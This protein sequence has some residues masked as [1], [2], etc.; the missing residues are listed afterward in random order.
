M[1]SSCF[2]AEDPIRVD[3]S[4][5]MNT[6]EQGEPKEVVYGFAP[7]GALGARD[8][9]SRWCQASPT[10]HVCALAHSS[11]GKEPRKLVFKCKFNRKL[12]EYPVKVAWVAEDTKGV[13]ACRS[14]R[15]PDVTRAWP[16]RQPNLGA[17]GRPRPVR[18]RFPSSPLLR[19]SS[20]QA[21]PNN[22]GASRGRR[23]A[24]CSRQCGLAVA[25]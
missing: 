16:C 11:D 9:L 17:T 15:F 4:T 23:R 25:W 22:H 6:D 18:A 12:A 19:L 1:G 24:R 8:L 3:N 2:K 10:L 7:E 13:R 14:W 20:V 21:A 5:F